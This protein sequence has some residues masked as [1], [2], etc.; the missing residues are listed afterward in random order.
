M[1]D[2][3]Q[4]LNGLAQALLLEWIV[5]YERK[6]LMLF[7]V[8]N[9]NVQLAVVAAVVA[10]VEMLLLTLKSTTISRMHLLLNIM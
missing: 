3:Y 4:D 9:M 6:A 1:A 10:V 8:L 2:N 5:G 7:A